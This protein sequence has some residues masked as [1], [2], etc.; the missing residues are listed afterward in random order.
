MRTGLIRSFM[1]KRLFRE[2]SAR[3][4]IFWQAILPASPLAYE[5]AKGTSRLLMTMA[6]VEKLFPFPFG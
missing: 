2:N 1:E 6:A 5:F 4:C 3:N